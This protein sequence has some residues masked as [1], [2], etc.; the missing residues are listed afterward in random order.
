MFVYCTVRRNQQ[1]YHKQQFDD[2]VTDFSLTH[3]VSINLWFNLTV[4][5]ELKIIESL[6]Y[7]FLEGIPTQPQYPTVSGYES[8][9][10]LHIQ[11]FHDFYWHLLCWFVKAKYI[12]KYEMLFK[13][14][15]KLIFLSLY[16]CKYQNGVRP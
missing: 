12:I 2:N 6:C 14:L 4:I 10:L 7:W 9:A 3:C 11:A 16:S 1:C 5:K 15:L 8:L 13:F